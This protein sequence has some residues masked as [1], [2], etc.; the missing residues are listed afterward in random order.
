VGTVET[1]Q[2]THVNFAKGFRGGERQTQLLIEELA[3]HGYQ[4]KLLVRKGSKLIARCEQ[5]KDLTIVAINKP[6]VL[7]LKHVKE[8]TLLHAHET[9]ALQFVYAAHLLYRLPYVVTRRVDNTIKNNWLNQHMYTSAAVTVAL[10]RAIKEEILKVAPQANITIIPSAFT[11]TP[12]DLETSKHIKARFTKKFLVGHVG[13]LDDRHKGQSFIIEAARLLEKSHPDIHFI[14]VGGGRDEVMLKQQAEGLSNITFEGFVNNVNDYINTFDLFIFP[15]RNEGLGSIL[16]DVMRL[17]VP[18]IASNVG[19]I[20]DIITD[21]ETG[22]LIPPLQASLLAEKV[23]AL[24]QDT[25]L[26]Q[27]LAQNASHEVINYSA[28]KMASRYEA[29]YQTIN[30]SLFS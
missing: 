21:G 10:S 27:I 24:H 30:G 18:I 20:P 11:D 9:K 8:S 4:Q 3:Q 17:N 19:G 7:S 22:V 16:F 2:I 13:A 23:L 28:P 25:S 14:L 5:I 6:Y 15:S 1:M 12:L 29:L 26:C